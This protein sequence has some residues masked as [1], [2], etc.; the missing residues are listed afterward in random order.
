MEHDPWT[1]PSTIGRRTRAPPREPVSVRWTLRKEGFLVQYRRRYRVRRWVVSVLYGSLFLLVAAVFMVGAKWAVAMIWLAFGLGIG[2]Y[3]WWMPRLAG[4]RFAKRGFA[5]GTVVTSSAT[6]HGL[7]TV[8]PVS[9]G[10]YPYHQVKRVHRGP[11]HLWI[12]LPGNSTVM[13]DATMVVE[14]DLDQFGQAL[15]DAA[16]SEDQLGS[17]E[18]ELGEGAIRVAVRRA[19]LVARLWLWTRLLLSPRYRVFWLLLALMLFLTVFGLETG[20]LWVLPVGVLAVVVAIGILL[21]RGLLAQR[22]SGSD[23]RTTFAL[24][25][26]TLHVWPFFGARHVAWPVERMTRLVRSGRKT[27]IHF[28]R[29]VLVLDPQAAVEGDV[30]ALIS[31]L[32]E[33]MGNR[34]G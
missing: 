9:S 16:G 12:V 23:G 24:D 6:E 15:E 5:E 32:H 8:S 17:W 13:I 30:E 27:M 33:R 4:R 11:D 25:G 31:D 18:S 3:A 10:T 21:V 29:V 20:I 34:S 14:G 2:S 26:D 22:T 28:D 1:P 7:H 19:N